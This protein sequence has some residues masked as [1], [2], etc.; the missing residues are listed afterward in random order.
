M[1]NASLIV[2]LLT[3]GVV[4]GLVLQR[5][6][7]LGGGRAERW[8][9]SPG[10]SL[11]TVSAAAYAAGFLGLPVAPLPVAAVVGGFLGAFSLVRRFWP[12]QRLR[13]RPTVAPAPPWVMVLLVIPSVVIAVM[14]AAANLAPILPPTLHD[15]VDHATYV[16][17]IIETQS[18]DRS[19]LS[20]PP[21]YLNGEPLFY[22]W[23]FHA[24]V[25]LV[26][27]STTM[28]PMSVFTATLVSI[29]AM[30]PLSVYGFSTRLFGPGWPSLTAAYASLVLWELPFEQWRWGGYAILTGVVAGLAFVSLAMRVPRSKP[31]LAAAGA[32]AFG[33][34]LIHPS[35]AMAAL[36]LTATIATVLTMHGRY[37]VGGA[38]AFLAMAGVAAAVFSIG[39]EVWQ[40]LAEFAERA[41]RDGSKV[42]GQAMWQW[43]EG[44]YG[45][46][47][48]WFEG[49]GWLYALAIV[50]AIAALKTPAGRALVALHALASAMIAMIPAQTWLTM[51]FYH[52]ADRVWY[53]HFAALA[54]M[55][56]LGLATCARWVS[57]IFIRAG[58]SPPRPSRLWLALLAACVVLF[59]GRHFDRAFA[60]LERY[61]HGPLTYRDV[62]ALDDYRFIATHVRRGEVIFNSPRD[63]GLALPFTGHR[64]VFWRAGVAIPE[65]RSPW[66]PTM[67]TFH[68]FNYPHLFFP[69]AVGFLADH[70]INHVYAA[71]FGDDAPIPG[72]GRQGDAPALLVESLDL[73]P[74]LE[75]VYRSR[76]GSIYRR[77][78]LWQRILGIEPVDGVT[79]T[80]FYPVESREVPPY[81]W[82]DGRG[83]VAVA[84]LETPQDDCHVVVGGPKANEFEVYVDD[85]ALS[86]SPFGF[87]MPPDW[88]SGGD[89]TFE[90]R[91]ESSVPAEDGS[92]DDLRRL[93]ILVTTLAIVCPVPTAP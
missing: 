62:K 32:L 59:A 44:L 53:M 34:L 56:G 16:R 86:R 4:P 5:V 20:L 18:L 11:A 48:P 2:A 25:A 81:R 50:G 57:G 37:P 74:G 17:M 66:A 52:E 90:V 14:L 3:W 82:T 10:L 22:P 40:P 43:P 67:A 49:R 29:S 7:R 65:V 24:F 39:P 46:L 93:G 61:G 64:Y 85:S 60:H 88:V 19:V 36:L 1:G 41:S 21:F 72:W 76:T 47:T 73:N 89:F 71:T 91:S 51:I 26:A 27:Q 45:V 84:A 42:A 75:L 28:T 54:T 12:P 6:I 8:A 58:A 83:T 68:R 33:L 80:G 23:G 63:W 30:M 13:E 38:V 15:G 79:I 31:A 35:Q 70:Q 78:A 92:S 69:R 87:A 77:R 9:L 55:V